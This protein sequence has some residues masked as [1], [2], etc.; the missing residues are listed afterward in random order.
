M[1]V[2]VTVNILIKQHEIDQLFETLTA[3]EAAVADAIIVQDLAVARIAKTHFPA[4][5]TRDESNRTAEFFRARFQQ[6]GWGLWAVELPGVAGFL[7]FTGLHAV[8]DKMP[9]APAVEVGWRL[10]ARWWNHGYA[11]E[12]ARAAIAFGFGTLGLNE[13]V[14]FTI[15]ANTTSR[16]VMEKLGMT[17]D[18][19]DNFD[20]PGVP[21]GD[22]TR[23]HVLYRLARP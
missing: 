19:A 18:P 22:P 7:G 21:E 23:P 10:A 14:S 11:T 3:I 15:P 5:L 1:K 12:A 6:N 13:I 17:H 16:R 4:T 8:S 2:L 9:F 20:H